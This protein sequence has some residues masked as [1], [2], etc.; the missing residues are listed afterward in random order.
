MKNFVKVSLFVFCLSTIVNAQITYRY[1]TIEDT[2][3]LLDLYK[4]IEKNE[5]DRQKL[6]IA[7]IEMRKSILEKN[8][9]AG[10]IFVAEE[11]KQ[12]VS[13]MKMFIISDKEQELL[14]ITKK[15]LNLQGDPVINGSYM[16]RS[17]V[18]NDFNYKLELDNNG[19]LNKSYRNFLTDGLVSCTYI[20]YGGAYT[21]PKYRKRYINTKVTQYAF[22]ILKEDIESGGVVLLYGQVEA[23]SKQVGII[24]AFA[25]FLYAGETVEFFHYACIAYKPELSFVDN[26]LKINFPEENKGY[27]NMIF[28]TLNF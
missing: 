24:K 8:L 3:Q 18:I 9:K 11:D 27:G 15:E 28:G 20:Y 22:K 6:L 4:L 25:Q 7:P 21:L 12:I 14:D 2:D 1:A 17:D 19:M 13:F 10:R 26:N 23:N 5:E 16:V